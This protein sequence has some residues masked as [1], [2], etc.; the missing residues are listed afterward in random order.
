M[1][2]VM[3]QLN[4]H[5]RYL[6][7]RTKEGITIPV[8]LSWGERF[9]KAQAKMDSGAENCL[10]RREIGEALNIDIESGLPKTFST[11]TGSIAAYG[12]E[13]TLQSFDLSFQSFV[14]FAKEYDLP[15]NLLGSIGWL[16]NLRV[17]LVDYEE[18]LYLSAYGS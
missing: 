16:R 2:R 18:L 17:G 15:R 1:K 9:E 3:H 10:F 7:N 6:Y 11:L 13:V 8:T 14:Y 5:L 12:H 4:F